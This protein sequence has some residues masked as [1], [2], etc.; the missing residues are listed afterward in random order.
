MGGR[1]RGLHHSLRQHHQHHKPR[2]DDVVVVNQPTD[3][4]VHLRHCSSHSFTP[5]TEGSFSIKENVSIDH[6]WLPKRLVEDLPTPCA[7][8]KVDRVCRKQLKIQKQKTLLSVLKT[9]GLPQL[10]HHYYFFEST[11]WMTIFYVINLCL[12]QKH[13]QQDLSTSEWNNLEA[14][15]LLLQGPYEV[16]LQSD[17]MTLAL[18]YKAIQ[19][20]QQGLLQPIHFPPRILKDVP[21]PP[22]TAASSAN[23]ISPK[24]LSDSH[25]NHLNNCSPDATTVSISLGFIT[26]TTVTIASVSTVTKAHSSTPTAAA[27]RTT[28][29]PAI[30]AITVCACY[31]AIIISTSHHCSCT[32][33]TTTTTATCAMHSLIPIVT[34]VAVCSTTLPASCIASTMT[35]YGCTTMA[36]C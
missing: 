21:E 28:T 20:L 29:M 26:T 23:A 5:G 19:A 25:H 36:Q 9:F 4:H 31:P 1:G 17:K 13:H 15:T 11:T 35:C 34:T 12:P 32:T 7:C 33:T 10:V 3:V 24:Q 22:A 8:V 2:I 27:C 6:N 14:L 16:A 30:T 18:A